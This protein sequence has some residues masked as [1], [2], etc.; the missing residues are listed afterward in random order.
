[1]T[2]D[3]ARLAAR[4]QSAQRLIDD[5]RTTLSRS[6]AEADKAKAAMAEAQAALTQAEADFATAGEAER[7]SGGHGAKGRRDLGASRNRP[8]R[9]PTRESD[10]R[11]KRSE[12]EGEAN[13]LRAEVAALARLVERDTAE[14]GQVLDLLTVQS[15]YEKALGAALADDLRAP[16][17]GPDAA[18]GWATLP[19]YLAAQTL[20]DGVAPLTQL[21]AGA[22]GFGPPHEPGGIGAPRRRRAVASGVEAGPA[23]GVAGR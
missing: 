20:P 7:A 3:V 17:I 12:A 21:C 8:R 16:A 10:A 2:E 23:A 18:S 5:N 4:H 19:P 9:D 22:R 14:G 6:Q 1:M 13:A 15:G 11:V